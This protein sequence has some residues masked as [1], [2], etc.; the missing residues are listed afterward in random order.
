MKKFI[1]GVLSLLFVA[2]AGWSMAQDATPAADTSVVPSKGKFEIRER[3]RY[4]AL[5]I[6][7]GVKSGVLS[8]DQAA[9]LRDSLKS[10]VQQAKADFEQNGRKALTDDQKAQINQ[11]LDNNSKAIYQAKHPG[12][13]AS[14]DSQA[15]VPD[16]TND[17][18]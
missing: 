8:K 1:A 2:M 13:T 7:Q 12:Q 15:A 10:I 17:G 6:A 9:A 18:N 4:Q 14:G 16:D 5:R 3:F 11:L